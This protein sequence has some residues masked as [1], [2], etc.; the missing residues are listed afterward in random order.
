[1]RIILCGGGTAGHVTPA[2]AVAKE[3]KRQDPHS[4][5]LFIGRE[6]GRENRA[7]QN[8]G[9]GL[10]TIKVRGLRRRLSA[11]NLKVISDAMK[12][13]RKA[14]EIIKEFRPDVILGTGGYVC[15]PVI[16]AGRE[17]GI[18]T[19]I[20]ESNVTPGLTTRMLAPMCNLLLLGQSD[21]SLKLY[22]KGKKV[23]VGNPLPEDFS[24]INRE[25]ARRGLGIKE[26]EIFILSFGGSIGSERMNKVIIELIEKYSTKEKE[27]KHL[28]ATGERYYDESRFV[29]YKSENF[30]CKILPYID[31]MPRKLCAADIVICRCGALT[32][33]EISAAGVAAIL[34]P[35]P[36][37]PENHQYKNAK[38]I[39]DSGAAIMIE[40]KYLSFERLKREVNGL[41]ND[42][43]GRKNKAK[44]I[45]ALST[46][47]AAKAVTEQ[48][49]LL[50]NGR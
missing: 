2:I 8:A 31:D 20:H 21:T 23:V 19:A 39:C 12:A 26:N 33:S 48:L 30:G 25:E 34:I 42:K 11:E 1:M 37:V 43:N 46:P 36:N 16:K 22:C 40:E 3:I 15:W 14:K 4:A 32:L 5:I 18:K 38:K 41:K 29:K 45:F 7:V 49:K 47:Y 44:R 28:H 10:K 13:K 24:K 6:G 50:K 35:S 9:I 27:I 17:L